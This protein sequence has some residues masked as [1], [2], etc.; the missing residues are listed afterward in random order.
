MGRVKNKEIIN[1]LK[2]VGKNNKLLI[3]NGI[4]NVRKYN[5]FSIHIN[6]S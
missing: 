3:L 5:P 6:N 2:N 4:L 1:I